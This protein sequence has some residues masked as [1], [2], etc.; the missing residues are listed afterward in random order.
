MCLCAKELAFRVGLAETHTEQRGSA[1]SPWSP[2]PKDGC[3]Q[4][5]QAERVPCD[6]RGRDHPG[7]RWL[8]QDVPSCLLPK[9]APTCNGTCLE[10]G[11]LSP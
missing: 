8:Q 4:L 3:F 10:P 9:I 11:S 2:N 7:W 1:L 6:I 5:P